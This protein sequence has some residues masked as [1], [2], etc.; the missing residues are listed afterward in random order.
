MG[1]HQNSREN[2]MSITKRL[3][4][5]AAA[6]FAVVAPFASAQAQTVTKPN[7]VVMSE[8]AD[9]DTVPRGNRI[10]NR[11]I[12]E[13]GEVM[14]LRGYNIYD[15]TAV[16]MNISEPGRVRRRDAEIIDVAR[17]VQTP[18]VDIIAVFQIYASATKSN[19]SD[20]VRPNIRIPG[21]LLNVRTGQQ[22]ASFEVT[23]LELA[24]L[25]QNCDKECLLEKVG[26]EAK[27]IA[28]ELA[29]ALTSKLDGFVAPARVETP[30]T[31]TPGTDGG[32]VAT[33]DDVSCGGL[34]TAFV[35]RV[36][37]FEA[38]EVLAI[39]EYLR[40][41]SCYSHQRPV[42]ATPAQSEYWYETRADSARLNRN[43]RL[44]LE[45]MD[46]GGQVSF[47]GNTFTVTK[48]GTR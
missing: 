46:A 7:I 19:V 1:H 42:R 2:T 22:I 11:V 33:G 5:A 16:A 37:G 18:P 27:L 8:D 12:L 44:M 15:E 43:L 35:I 21:R 24:P 6:A 23:G 13:L 20:I 47:A 10:F 9:E 45:H 34:P 25:P 32:T 28:N 14:N 17:A 41:F 29:Q 4:I 36:T 48:I 3:F 31:T 30:I 26:G 38:T 40:A 39:E